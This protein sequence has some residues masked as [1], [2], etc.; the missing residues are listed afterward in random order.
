VN[1]FLY[2][3]GR[4]GDQHG[5]RMAAEF[6]RRTSRWARIEMREIRSRHAGL[7]AKH[8]AATKIALDPEGRTLSSA[9]FA[10]LVREAELSARELVFLVGGADGLPREWREGADMLLSLSAMTLPHGLARV[11]IAEQIYRA[12]ATLRGHPY[13]R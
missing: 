11:V 7:L 8:R 4:G 12:F 5:E 3:I 2:F 9:G 13:P 6:V 10:K 1:V